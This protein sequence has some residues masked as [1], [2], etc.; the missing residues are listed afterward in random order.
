MQ[1]EG[2]AGVSSQVEMSSGLQFFDGIITDEIQQILV[3]SASD[4]IS[5][6]KPN[7][8]FVAGRL[9]LFSL[10]KQVFKKDVG[11]PT[12]LYACKKNV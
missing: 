3:K 11:S 12:I 9:L 6:D 10:R 5:L 4:L 8:Q 7:Y 1:L 2:I